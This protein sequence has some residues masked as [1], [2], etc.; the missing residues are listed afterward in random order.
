ELVPALDLLRGPHGV[1]PG[2]ARGAARAGRQV[3]PGPLPRGGARARHAAGEIPA[4]TGAPAV[5]GT[6]LR[7]RAGAGFSF[8]G[9]A[10]ERTA[11][12]APPRPKQREPPG[13]GVFR[14]NQALEA[15]SLLLARLLPSAGAAIISLD[16]PSRRIPACDT[17]SRPSYRINPASSPRFR[18]CSPRGPSTSTAWP[19]AR[20]RCPTCRA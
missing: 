13:H 20:P 7:M 9:S 12:E 1:L 6:A 11:R 16:R 14:D 18:A 15:L 4:G 8:P 19:S 10:W 17:C 2:A 3:R 5:E